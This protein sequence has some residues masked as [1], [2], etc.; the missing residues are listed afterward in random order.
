MEQNA[1]LAAQ[2]K[3]MLTATEQSQ[4]SLNSAVGDLTT[5]AL[6]LDGQP[7]W[8]DMQARQPMVL[9]GV[10]AKGHVLLED[11]PGTAKTVLARAIAEG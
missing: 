9:A 11:V 2:L 4:K 3:T 7:A 10:L 6:G 8:I 1:A 5:Q